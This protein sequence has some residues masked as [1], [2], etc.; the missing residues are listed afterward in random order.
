MLISLGTHA[1]RITDTFENAQHAPKG[2]SAMMSTA[3]YVRRYRS[4]TFFLRDIEHKRQM[5][6]PHREL[7]S[8]RRRR[9]ACESRGAGCCEGS[10]GAPA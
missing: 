9:C 1:C 5:N 3:K 2:S 6:V 7:T 8:T 4:A 10:M